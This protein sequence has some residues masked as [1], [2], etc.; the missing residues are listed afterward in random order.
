MT[1]TI[2]CSILL[3]IPLPLHITVYKIIQCTVFKMSVTSQKFYILESSVVARQSHYM[4]V[5]IILESY[6]FS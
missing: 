1:H 3:S 6:N 4:L 2:A 5:Y